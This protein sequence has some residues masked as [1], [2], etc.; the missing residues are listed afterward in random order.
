MMRKTV[1]MT[2]TLAALLFT[3]GGIGWAEGDTTEKAKEA[4]KEDKTAKA[5]EMRA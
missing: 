1:V 3:F 5:R 4:K 2:L